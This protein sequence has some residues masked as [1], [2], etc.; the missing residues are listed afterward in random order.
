MNDIHFA[1]IEDLNSLLNKISRDTELTEES[2]RYDFPPKFQEKKT[3]PDVK[4]PPDDDIEIQYNDSLNPTTV[5]TEKIENLYNKSN[6]SYADLDNEQ[7]DMAHPNKSAFVKFKDIKTL[8]ELL[9]KHALP[10]ARYNVYCD[11]DGVLVDFDGG[12]ARIFGEGTPNE[13]IAAHSKNKF[14]KALRSCSHFF[15]ELDWLPDGEALWSYIQQYNPI[16]LTAPVLNMEH[17]ET[18]K[19]EWVKRHL[20]ENVHVIVSSDKSAFADGAS[21]LIDDQDKNILPWVA[22]GGIAIK[23]SSTDDTINRLEEIFH[24]GYKPSEISPIEELEK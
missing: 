14:F 12:F 21:V 18:D 20:G 1:D 24:E 8:D 11:L 2:H 23:H 5:P 10:Q 3:P 17:C 15:R 16:I 19:I 4:F 13:F 9:F 7:I 22:A 6:T